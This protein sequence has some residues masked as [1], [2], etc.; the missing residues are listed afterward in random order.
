M[1]A[2]V[3][4]IVRY[5]YSG[6]DV[7]FDCVYCVCVCINYTQDG[8]GKIDKGELGAL[9]ASLGEELTDEE[10]T[11]LMKEIDADGDGEVD[12]EEFKTLLAALT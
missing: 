7:N 6:I 10:L 11:A 8:S 9:L 2:C 3:H 4:I 12:F 5:V 1:C